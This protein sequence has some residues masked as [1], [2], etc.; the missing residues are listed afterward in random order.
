MVIG[1]LADVETLAQGFFD[2]HPAS[3]I[4][5]NS[6]NGGGETTEWIQIAIF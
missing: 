5:Q 3:P 2:P 4:F 1:T 6:E